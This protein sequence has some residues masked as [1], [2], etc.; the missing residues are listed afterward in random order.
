MNDFS[1]PFIDL[2]ARNLLKQ[3]ASFTGVCIQKGR[4]LSLG[5]HDGTKELFVVQFQDLGNLF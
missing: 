4:E 1:D 5:K 3:L 2:F